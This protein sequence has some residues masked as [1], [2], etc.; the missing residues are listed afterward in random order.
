MSLARERGWKLHQLPSSFT[1]CR[2][3]RVSSLTYSEYR[4]RAQRRESAHA[5]GV[6]ANARGGVW[7][8]RQTGARWMR[9]PLRVSLLQRSWAYRGAPELALHSARSA[10]ARP[11]DDKQPRGWKALSRRASTG[12]T[13]LLLAQDGQVKKMYSIG[14]TCPSPRRLQDTRE[15]PKLSTPFGEIDTILGCEIQKR[16]LY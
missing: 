3:R 14:C 1:G 6:T 16:L 13:R 15:A 4:G 5:R 11:I 8:A 10:G 7:M 9:Q 12:A 2:S